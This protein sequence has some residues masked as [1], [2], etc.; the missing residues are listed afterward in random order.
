[1]YAVYFRVE[2]RSRGLTSQSDFRTGNRGV[3]F[4]TL[5]I[6]PTTKL[7]D[8][9]G[10]GLFDVWETEGVRDCN[11]AV[12]LD[13]EA[14]GADPDHK[15]I[16]VE[17]DWLPGRDPVA[18]TIAG[19]K[20]AFAAAPKDAGGVSNP[21]DAPGITLW[22][23]TGN[24]ATGD[25][26][27]GGGEIDLDDVPN[28]VSVSKL[29]GDFDNNNIADFYDVKALY[30][31]PNR[32]FAFHYVI[33]GPN[34]TEE[35]G[36]PAG[37]CT[38][39]VDND[40]DGQV[41]GD[42]VANCFSNSQGEGVGNDFFLNVPGSGIF[43]HELGHNLGLDH[44]G[45][46]ARNCKPNYVSVMNYNMQNGIPQDTIAGQDTDADGVPDNRII[47]YSPP[48]F[49]G[50]RG[51]APLPTLDENGA[52]A[53]NGN[54]LDETVILDPSDPENMTVFIDAMG[55][56]QTSA[57]DAPI[58]WNGDGVPDDTGVTAN[59]NSGPASGCSTEPLDG[60]P[61]V[62]QDDWSLI[63]MNFRDAGD[64]KDGAV[65]PTEEPEPTPGEL[66]DLLEAIYTTDLAVTKTV[67]RQPVGR[68]PGGGDHDLG[69]EPGPQPYPAGPGHGRTGRHVEPRRSAVHLHGRRRRR[70]H[71]R[72]GPP[73]RE[74]HGRGQTARPHRARLAMPRRPAVCVHQQHSGS[75]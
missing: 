35:Q 58:D 23:D 63:V 69:R 16:F 70:G 7:S 37:S 57:L 1:M 5:T 18:S 43:M 66:E 36:A 11:D 3:F 53:L 31:N 46:E 19:V 27:G 74:R 59:V 52:D 38:D 47:D 30:F 2:A 29:G 72:S 4:E 60:D 13:L 51:I 33:G 44:G 64:S 17:Y 67:D 24:A 49:P 22:V 62:G 25:D 34:G 20:A 42:D 41:D 12:V 32:R 75:G 9:D 48:R 56:T 65:N 8:R 28:G 14:L 26:L 68:R 10:D 21:D 39:G 50:G 6:A 55:A 61:H 71:L 45:F 40:G 54:G 15:D 73:A